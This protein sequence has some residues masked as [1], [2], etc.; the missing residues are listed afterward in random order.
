[1]RRP[2]TWHLIASLFVLLSASGSSVLH[3]Q[4]TGRL[5]LPV[6]DAVVDSS[7]EQVN[8]TVKLVSDNP[9]DTKAAAVLVQWKG[10]RWANAQ[11]TALTELTMPLGHVKDLSNP[12]LKYELSYAIT[13]RSGHT[14]AGPTFR[15]LKAT[16]YTAVRD[17][18]SM[19]VSAPF[20]GAKRLYIVELPTVDAGLSERVDRIDLLISVTSDGGRIV[21]R[22]ETP[23]VTYDFPQ[24][25]WILRDTGSQRNP[26]RTKLSIRV[27]SAEWATRKTPRL[28]LH[29]AIRV[30]GQSTTSREQEIPLPP[31][32][33]AVLQAP[34]VPVPE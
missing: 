27:D 18:A 3:A 16:T 5:R 15:E 21:E 22:P 32:R 24:S 9:D 12:A 33:T 6:I 17:G 29:Y 23:S 7:L 34:P 2:P 10:G 1:M 28:R 13:W 26:A 25:G 4:N 31:G 11:G 30:K 8:L 14:S 20:A 19:V